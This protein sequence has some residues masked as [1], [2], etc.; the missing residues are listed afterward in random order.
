MAVTPTGSPAWVRTVSHTDYGGDTDKQNYLSKGVI[1]P[2]TDVGAEAWSRIAADLS[3]CARVAPFA[4]MLIRMNDTSP[5]APTIL[6]CRMMTGVRLTSYEGNAA[7][8]GFPSAVRDGTGICTITFAS[9]Y[10]DPYSVSG[11]LSMTNAIATATVSSSAFGTPVVEGI[12]A[13]Q[14]TIKAFDAAGSA[15]ADQTIS[16]DIYGGG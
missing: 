5:A 3:A 11:G 4:T 1:D 10:A 15:L 16:V 7:P 9:T 8:S 14:L 12:S 6:A 13:T 2:R